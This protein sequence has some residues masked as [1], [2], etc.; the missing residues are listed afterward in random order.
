M[1]GLLALSARCRMAFER[2]GIG[3]LLPHREATCAQGF[4]TLAGRNFAAPGGQKI[5]PAENTLH[6]CLPCK[7]RPMPECAVSCG[8]KHGTLFG[9]ATPKMQFNSKYRIRLRRPHGCPHETNGGASAVRE[10][11]T[12]RFGTCGAKACCSVHVYPPGAR[13][14]GFRQIPLWASSG[15]QAGFS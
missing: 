8:E 12:F 13:P 6:F 9:A 3:A 15:R 7:R 10:M 5:W 1:Y 4:A 11:K 2:H 14:R